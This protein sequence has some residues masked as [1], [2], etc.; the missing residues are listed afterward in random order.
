MFNE[1][2][3]VENETD[4]KQKQCVCVFIHLLLLCPDRGHSGPQCHAAVLA[5]DPV[6]SVLTEQETFLS[7]RRPAGWT[8]AAHPLCVRKDG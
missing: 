6:G 1:Y 5:A 2:I 7:L 3:K 8:W 4:Q